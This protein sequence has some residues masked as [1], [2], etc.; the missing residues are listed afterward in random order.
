MIRMIIFVFDY[1]CK[2]KKHIHIRKR[3]Y[4]LMSIHTYLYFIF[5]KITNFQHMNINKK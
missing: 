3:Q 5:K 4:K 2:S 1:N